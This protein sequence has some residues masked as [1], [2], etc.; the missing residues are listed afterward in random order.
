MQMTSSTYLLLVFGV[1]RVTDVF[2]RRFDL[3]NRMHYVL[4]LG[5][6]WL[7]KIAVTGATLLTFGWAIFKVG[8]VLQL[9]R[10]TFHWI[11]L[12]MEHFEKGTLCTIL[13]VVMC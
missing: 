10:R 1:A 12:K 13:Q 9:P 8:L 2:K 5:V 3:V 4:V 7:C 11:V 6:F